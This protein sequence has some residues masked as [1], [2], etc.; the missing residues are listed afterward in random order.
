MPV[1]FHAYIDESGD[2]GFAFRPWPDR[3]SSEWFVVAACVVR[4]EMH[5]EASAKL[6]AIIDPIEGGRNGTPIHFNKLNHDMRIGI[7]HQLAGVPMRTIAVCFHKPALPNGHTLAGNR[8]LYFYAVRYLI[9]RISWLAREN[10]PIS[11]GDKRCRLNFSKC[12]NLAY[13]DLMRYLN[14]LKLDKT[15]IDW[16]HLD[17]H[18][19]KVAKH[20]SSIWLRC[21]DFVASAYAKGLEQNAFGLCE[22]RYA[23][24]LKPIA[25]RHRNTYWSYGL[26][27]SPFV[28]AVERNKDNRYAWLSLFRG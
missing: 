6:H 14:K 26:K 12:K 20:E 11:S 18:M 21:A 4:D 10:A 28:P 22:D 2:E 13:D 16:N 23:R 17:T 3:G 9:E 7:A 5:S 8:R 24:L 15:Q 27:V 19:F 1:S 25:F